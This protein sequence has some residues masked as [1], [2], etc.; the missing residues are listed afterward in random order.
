MKIKEYTAYNETEVLDLY[1]S[2]GWSAYT[3]HPESLQK[4]FENSLL[5][6]AAWDDTEQLIGIIR[7]RSEE[8][9]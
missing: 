5:T 4:G 3:D 8:R 7:A 9:V 6:L 2:V 1:A